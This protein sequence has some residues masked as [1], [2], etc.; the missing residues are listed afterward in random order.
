[1]CDVGWVNP[2]RPLRQLHHQVGLEEVPAY[3]RG[4]LGLQQHLLATSERHDVPR[5]GLFELLVEEG[6]VAVAADGEL[7]RLR[8][9]VPVNDHW[10]ASASDDVWPGPKHVSHDPLRYD[11]FDGVCWS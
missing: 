9:Y 6:V 2:A 1:M 8:T 7:D 11:V 10:S 5:K 4:V 3:R